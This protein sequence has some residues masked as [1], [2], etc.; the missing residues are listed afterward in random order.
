MMNELRK[1]HGLTERDPLPCEV[2]ET[3]PDAPRHPYDDTW[4]V[5]CPSQASEAQPLPTFQIR[6]QSE[7]FQAPEAT[8]PP[9]APAV[10]TAALQPQDHE[11]AI[12]SAADSV[13]AA[14][15]ML[16]TGSR[17]TTPDKNTMVGVEC[18]DAVDQGRSSNEAKE[19]GQR[20]TS[21]PV[22][23][24]DVFK[25]PQ[26]CLLRFEPQGM[27]KTSP[28]EQV[29]FNL[30]GT[31]VQV[32]TE[33]LLKHEGSKIA[34]IT[35]SAMRV[36]DM[37]IPLPRDYEM[38]CHCVFYVCNEKVQLPPSV[39]RKDFMKEMK[40][41]G[42]PFD[43]TLVSGGKCA[44][45]NTSTSKLDSSMSLPHQQQI[46]PTT[47][48]QLHY[49]AAAAP[50]PG[51]HQ[52][53]YTAS[54][55]GASGEPRMPSPLDLLSSAMSSFIG[56]SSRPSSPAPDLHHPG[57]H[58]GLLFDQNNCQSVTNGGALGDPTNQTFLSPLDLLTSVISST[59]GSWGS[60]P[61][62][63]ATQQARNTN[64]R[65]AMCGKC[66]VCLRDDCGEC[67]FCLDK[68][69]FGGPNRLRKKCLMRRCANMNPVPTFDASFYASATAKPLAIDEIE[70]SMDDG[71]I[72]AFHRSV[73]EAEKRWAENLEFLRPCIED[74]GLINYAV[75]P[76]DEIRNRIKNFVKECRKQHRRIENNEST[77]LTEERLRLLEEA[78]F[79]WSHTPYFK[80]QDSEVLEKKPT[81]SLDLLCSITSQS[82]QEAG[83]WNDDG[84]DDD[85]AHDEEEAEK[86][87]SEDVEEL[88]TTNG[89]N[90]GQTKRVRG[91][92]CGTCANCQR[93]DCGKCRA[94][95]D[96]PKF[97][98]PNKSRRRCFHRR[99]LIRQEKP[100]EKASEYMEID[101]IPV[102]QAKPV[103]RIGP[104]KPGGN[105]KSEEE[106]MM[107]ELANIRA[108]L[109]A[110]AR[111]VKYGLKIRSIS[112]IESLAREI[113][114]EG[115]EDERSA[116]EVEDVESD[117][118]GGEVHYDDDGPRKPRIFTASTSTERGVTVR[119]SGKWVS[120]QH[121]LLC[122]LCVVHFLTDSL[123][124]RL[125]NMIP[126]AS[127]ALLRWKLSVHWSFRFKRGGLVGVRNRARVHELIQRI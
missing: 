27:R 63:Y 103:N 38:F 19:P 14:A 104:R 91:L 45:P 29:K 41:Y 31:V 120:F 18:S 111:G 67:N 127:S 35:R 13:A 1:R 119:P 84:I 54:K 40:Y 124:F 23:E 113:E 57:L 102:E 8:P 58:G 39:R 82:F 117:D 81:S 26:G 100:D 77:S 64:V 90:P 83:S 47:V 33:I 68:P 62:S 86:E 72:M 51:P 16:M 110:K 48:T 3:L 125:N 34:A 4:P 126:T 65:K 89:S 30:R 71:K 10:A 61:S 70:S 36:G 95:I 92:N 24:A 122:G 42:I 49:H 115:S 11:D 96:K 9:A 66:E 107:A 118:G 93:D 73:I 15:M 123:P 106:R 43:E 105:H 59:D 108:E 99:C 121:V 20:I 79:P 5:H 53:G 25:L 114:E 50:D 12:S 112:T 109:D 101:T 85:D 28:R 6:S 69:K 94:C 7:L 60:K 55:F 46:S 21:S 44:S 37:A 76:D 80:N 22:V 75:I 116:D 74:G 88:P 52:P 56:S 97:G 32:P 78:N 2:L 98:G 87:E 17:A